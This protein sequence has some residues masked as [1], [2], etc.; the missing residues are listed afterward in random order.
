MKKS[1]KQWLRHQIASGAW[2]KQMPGTHRIL[3]SYIV[4][5]VNFR[6]I[7]IKKWP[8]NHKIFEIICSGTCGLKFL[9][10]SLPYI[11]LEETHNS[12]QQEETV[13]YSLMVKE[14]GTYFASFSP[15]WTFCL[16]LINGEALIKGEGGI[17]FKT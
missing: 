1:T 7:S 8:G 13:Q 10:T 9:S 12:E 16:K 4:T 11:F 2:L 17:F 3:S 6:E 5:T 14:P 15:K